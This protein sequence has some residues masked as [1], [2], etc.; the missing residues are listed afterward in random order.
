MAI[1]IRINKKHKLLLDACYERNLEAARDLIDEGLDLTEV[2][3][4]DDYPLAVALINNDVAMVR[5]LAEHNMPLYINSKEAYRNAESDAEVKDKLLCGRWDEDS[6]DARLA[7]LD[8]ATEVNTKELSYNG[9]CS[10]VSLQDHFVSEKS[11]LYFKRLLEMGA[12][13]DYPNRRG[14]R[15]IHFVA[16]GVNAKYVEP[17]IRRS[18]N[19]DVGDREGDFGTPL[20]R[21]ANKAL[22]V[23]VKALLDMGADPNKYD[24]RD[25]Q[26]ILDNVIWYKER[27][28]YKNKNGSL[29]D[30]IEL[31]KAHGAKT[32]QQ[33]V[34]EGKAE[35]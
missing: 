21:N 18:K 9:L 20:Y 15:I 28:P 30:K 16:G 24:K 29:D 14:G 5:L 26:S 4:T 19:I 7:L 34:E 27:N 35:A 1:K 10:L 11:D 22:V 12:D 17:L 33:L 31:L 32:Y 23:T 13:V 6:E 3:T 8:Y 2:W 25:K